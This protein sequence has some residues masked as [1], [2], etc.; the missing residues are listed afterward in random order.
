MHE[1][2][3][4]SFLLKPSHIP[5][6]GI[7]VFTTHCVVK[8]TRLAVMPENYIGRKLIRSQIPDEFIGFCEAKENGIYE[9]PDAFNHPYFAW[10]LNHSL[11]PNTHYHKGDYYA[12][13]DIEKGEEIT[14]DYN[15][16]GEPEHAKDD[17]YSK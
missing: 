1:T 11:D 14:I 2:N 6:A 12:I 8:G 4:F 15:A 16:I 3:E 17:Y 7:G 5:G 9:C 10:Y 13:R